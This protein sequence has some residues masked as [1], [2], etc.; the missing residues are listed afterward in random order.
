MTTIQKFDR[1][2]CRT[3]SA[4]AEEALAEVAEK[5]GLT[6]KK[7]SGRF[8]SEAFTFKLTFQAQTEDGVPAGFAAKAQALDLPTD[9]YGKVVLLRR[10]PYTIVD[11]NLRARKYPVCVKRVSDGR[12]YKYGEDSVRRALKDMTIEVTP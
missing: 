1:A 7:E 12:G 3:V 5:F 4:A 2:A 8:S 9:C 11:I 6:I 10:E